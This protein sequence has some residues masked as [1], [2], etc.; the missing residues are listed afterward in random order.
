MYM[1]IVHTHLSLSHTHT[2]T[3]TH[4]NNAPE[5]LMHTMMPLL[6]TP[7]TGSLAEQ[8][9]QTVLDSLSWILPRISCADHIMYVRQEVIY[10]LEID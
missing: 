3:H 9:A 5:Q 8:S 2:H 4:S 6:I 10:F 7:H 1:Y